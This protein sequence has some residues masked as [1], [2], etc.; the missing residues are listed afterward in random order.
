MP[1]PIS[2]TMLTTK[3]AAAYLGLAEATLRGWRCQGIGP[4]FYMISAKAARYDMADLK[5]Y[6]SERRCVPSVR[7]TEGNYGALQA[8]A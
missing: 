7:H 2:S 8:T 3:A 4:A 5:K 6:R 1:T